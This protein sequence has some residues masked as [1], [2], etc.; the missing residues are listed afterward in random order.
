MSNDWYIVEIPC[1]VG[2][3]GGGFND[4]INYYLLISMDTEIKPRITATAASLSLSFRTRPS[5]RPSA[6]PS[7][8]GSGS[9][10]AGRWAR[11]GYW[12]T[13]S[14]EWVSRGT[15]SN[16]QLSNWVLPDS[17]R[18]SGTQIPN[19]R[20]PSFPHFPPEWIKVGHNF[21][22]ITATEFDMH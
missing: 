10:A 7:A 21:I 14:T 18:G 2:G 5:F 1:R 9:P 8:A 12:G 3:N 17:G 11:V 20:R 16:G 13:V 19:C 15:Q 6:P 4:I 22:T